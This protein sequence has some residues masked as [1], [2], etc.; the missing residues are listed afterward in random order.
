MLISLK[1]GYPKVHWVIFWL[2]RKWPIWGTPKSTQSDENC[3]KTRCLGRCFPDETSESFRHQAWTLT[4]NALT[5]GIVDQCGSVWISVAGSKHYSHNSLRLWIQ[6]CWPRG[7]QMSDVGFSNDHL[8]LGYP[9]L[10]QKTTTDFC[11]CNCCKIL[12]V[13]SES[14]HV[15]KSNTWESP[16]PNNSIGFAGEHIDMHQLCTHQNQFNL[17]FAR[18]AMV[19]WVHSQISIGMSSDSARAQLRCG[20]PEL[21]GLRVCIQEK[22]FGIR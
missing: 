16:T 8:I 9:I 20:V 11:A 19:W 17:F 2:W 7:C 6:N 15:S 1:T 12:C 22:S 18:Q 3:A 10:T 14:F 5:S 4:T 21:H 13:A